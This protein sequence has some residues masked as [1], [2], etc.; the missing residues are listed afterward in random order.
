[1][2]RMSV[3]AAIFLTLAAMPAA[4]QNKKG[5][6]RGFVWN[7][8]PSI[9]F[10]KHVSVDLTGRALVEWRDISADSDKDESVF[11]LR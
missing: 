10:G 2:K 9:V 4:A 1:M 6:R 5:T 8:R 3:V 7:D 11:H